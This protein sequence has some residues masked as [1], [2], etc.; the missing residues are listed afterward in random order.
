MKL[1]FS[2]SKKSQ[3]KPPSASVNAA[4]RG[5]ADDAEEESRVYLTEFDASKAPSTDLG[6]NR[7]IPPLAN[8]WRPY[9]KM[10]NLDLPLQSDGEQPSLQFEVVEASA[11]DPASADSMSYG[12][13]LRKSDSNPSS[14]VNEVDPFLKKLRDDMERLP[15]DV[16]LNEYEDMP[17]EDFGRALMAG[18]GWVEGRGIGRNAKEDTKVKEVTRRTAKEGLGFTGPLPQI[19]GRGDGRK[20]PSDHI[21]SERGKSDQVANNGKD[22]GLHA[23]KEVRIVGGK[24]IGMKGKILELRHKGEVAYLRLSNSKE[25][26][27]V[28][29]RDLAELGS[30]EEERCL[31]KLKELKIRENGNATDKRSSRKDNME[32]DKETKPS[33]RDIG[34]G[35]DRKNEVKRERGET[36]V[37]DGH[38]QLPWLTSHIRVRI[39]SKHIKGGRLYLKKGE[40][41]DMAG[42]TTC[43]IKI[44][45]SRELIQGVDQGSLETAIPKRGGPVLILCGKHKGVYGT[46]VERDTEEETGVVQD[47][48]SRALINV[49]LEQIAEYMGD[50]SYIGY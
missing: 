19:P 25:E 21:N 35:R 27:K 18:M 46:L 7:V 12:L 2:L 11:T 10:K 33:R 50:P 45:E 5:G 24:E 42:P 28:Y 31:R 43:D 8:E 26:I 9:K 30:A 49:R 38:G 13:N 3:T 4:A 14:D 39:I 15:E 22:K 20:K 37:N 6:K 32:I 23:G 17:V 41:V 36:K 47:A 48:D 44:D 16:G 34:E 29:T 40:V 1:S